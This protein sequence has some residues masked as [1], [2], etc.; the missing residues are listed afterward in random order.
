MATTKKVFEW[1]KFTWLSDSSVIWASWQYDNSSYNIDTQTEPNWVK[2]TPQPQLLYSTTDTPRFILNANDY[3]ELWIF[4]FCDDWSIY[5]DWTS[6]FTLSSW[7]SIRWAVW[8]YWD[9]W[10]LYIIF[11]TRNY[12]HRLKYSDNSVDEDWIS[13]N[14]KDY[15]KNPLNIYWNIYF[16]SW[17]VFYKLDNIWTL[18]TIYTFPKQDNIAWI[19]FFQ[20]NFN[21]Y[22]TW[23]NYWRQY[24]F[25]ILSETPYYNIEWKWLPILWALNEW[26]LDYVVTWYNSSYSDLYLVSWTQKKA[27]KINSEW[28]GSRKFNWILHNRLGDMYI[29][30]S[31]NWDKKLFR[32]WNY[33]NWFSQELIPYLDFT[34][35]VTCINSSSTAL[36]VWTEDN[37]VYIINLNSIPDYYQSEWWITSLVSDF[38]TPDTK[39]Y[40]NELHLAYDN[41]WTNMSD[42]WWS[43]VLYARKFETD[44]WTELYSTDNLYNTWNIKMYQ[45]ELA[46]K[47][48]NDF[49]QLQFKVKLISRNNWDGF[50]YTPFFKKLKVIYTD[51]IN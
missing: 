38:W 6:V 40:L 36:Y 19:T 44:W 14:D 7:K 9:N 20:D 33:Y 16:G 4:S 1:K 3:W 8:Q 48:F 27:L 41:R 43:F 15:N 51:D 2:L 30:W 24:V 26:W 29:A 31:Y 25:P 22:T 5:R 47:W 28:S 12:I 45:T 13:I 50:L 49:Y 42:R 34:N 37:K 46:D 32:F 39:K 10:E 23:W 17:N 18:S 35:D 11:F 21:I